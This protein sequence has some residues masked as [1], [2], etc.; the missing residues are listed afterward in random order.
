MTQTQ[1]DDRILF[2]DDDDLNQTNIGK[3]RRRDTIAD[4]V[5]RGLAVTVNWA[6][7][8]INISEGQAEIQHGNAHY[9]LLPE[10]RENVPTDDD[11]D[12]DWYI[13]PGDNWL[14][15]VFDPDSSDAIWFEID[16]SASPGP[17]DPNL[18]IAEI[19]A[20]AETVT[21]VNRLPDHTVDHLDAESAE[22][23]AAPSDDTDVARKTEIDDVQADRDATQSQLDGHEAST[24]VHGS[25]GDV[26]GQNTLDAHTTD[27]T[28]PHETGLEQARTQ[29]D[30]ME[31]AVTVD[32]DQYQDHYRAVRDDLE[33]TLGPTTAGSG[34]WRLEMADNNS[35]LQGVQDGL[36]F[37]ENDVWNDGNASGKD[38]ESLGGQGGQSG[39]VLQTD[40]TTASWSTADV[41][42]ISL[43]DLE[44][45]SDLPDASSRAD[46]TIAYVA[47]IDDY[48]GVTQ[49]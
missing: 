7:D 43:L 38:A 35:Q 17:D 25:D 22:V 8:E 5:E 47:E 33:L 42:D 2:Q 32:S 27:T 3:S 34:G 18:L 12:P 9:T 39:Q 4:Y 13:Q 48:V 30:T 36:E 10:A 16:D 26:V 29:D 23:D 15:I 40:G 24:E 31:G 44:S 6:E 21:E 37:N 19:D 11:D 20:D 45:L 41:G 14:W 1:Q 49:E 28:N 46:P